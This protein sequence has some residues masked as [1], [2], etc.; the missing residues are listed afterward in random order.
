M[1]VAAFCAL[2]W[3]IDGQG[4]AAPY[5]D[6]VAKIR[7]QDEILY[8]GAAITMTKDGDWATPKVMGRLFFQKPPML[9]WM[10]A[11]SLKV[12][13][14]NLFAARLPAL[15][16]GAAGVAGV[17]WWVAAWGGAGSG[18]FAA[19]LLLLHPEWHTISR[20]AYTDVLAAGFTTLA[21][22]AIALDPK[23]NQKRTCVVFGAA[24]AAA[25]LS[26]S[27]AGLVPLL[28]F[29]LFLLMSKREERPRWPAL[30]LAVGV[31]AAV[32]A[33]WY[34]YQLLVHPRWFWADYVEQQLL[35]VGMNSIDIGVFDRPA[36]FWVERMWQLD[37][38]FT[39]V[40]VFGLLTTFTRKKA[41]VLLAWCWTL[42]ICAALA[43]F[44]AKNLPYLVLLLPPLSVL[45]GVAMARLEVRSQNLSL[46]AVL[47][48][49]FAK[50]WFADG[51]R[52]IRFDAPPIESTRS[53]RTYYSF[54]RETEL[55]MMNPDDEFWSSTIPLHRVRYGFVDPEETISR[56]APSYV[57]TGIIL[58]TDQLLSLDPAPYMAKFR[59][60]NADGTRAIGTTI[61]LESPNDVLRIA[62]AR[63][64]ADFSLPAT[65]ITAI[66]IPPTHD[67]R[68]LSRDR[69]F[70]FSRQVLSTQKTEIEL[71]QRW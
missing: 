16:L 64:R 18:L 4:L 17:F 6:A 23:V 13:G 70:L 63:P 55:F 54:G 49:A 62:A 3:D 41:G 66:E 59:A 5:S 30:L 9:M 28:A 60:L 7:A 11:A 42:T 48:L 20:V 22:L 31:F 33:P 39:V 14:W 25:I 40:A 29:G 57:P 1:F 21:L 8:V 36:S 47:I 61:L 58:K 71:P 67:V 32:L 65:W 27:V 35:G 53:L 37:P 24:C 50:M 26:K 34:V 10:S 19:A 52:A 15:L 12:L 45:A 44:Q 38:V 51:T 69:V 2:A 56:A 68:A 46:I 43:S